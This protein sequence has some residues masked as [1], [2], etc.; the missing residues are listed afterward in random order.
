MGTV[1]V[2]DWARTLPKLKRIIYVSSGAVYKHHGP[3]RPGEPLPEDGYVKPR[4]LYG[5]SKLANHGPPDGEPEFPARSQPTRPLGARRSEAG[6]SEHSGCGRRLPP[7]G[8]CRLRHD[9]V[10]LCNRTAIAQHWIA[11]HAVR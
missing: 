11:H 4:R 9:A 3:D 8:G 1:A 7:C 10:W 6:A 2:L 5:I